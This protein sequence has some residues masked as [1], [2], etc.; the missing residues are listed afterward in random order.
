MKKSLTAI[1]ALLLF[2]GAH[3]QDTTLKEYVGR[4]S[5]PPG[6]PFSSADIALSGNVLTASSEAGSS[7]LEKRGKDT[8]ALTAYNG[9]LYFFRNAEGKVARIKVEVSDLLVE[10]TKDG[11]TA[12]LQRR[13]LMTDDK[14]RRAVR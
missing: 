3:A 6:G 12:W 9:T 14:R 8:F 1:I 5:F 7:P 11:V 10:G 2:A 4:Y 13:Q